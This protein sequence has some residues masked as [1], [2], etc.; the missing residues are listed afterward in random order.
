MLKNKRFTLFL[1]LS[2]FFIGN[3]L[4]A[5][6]IGVKI[7]SL[8]ST[9]GFDPLDLTVFGV[10]GLGMNLSAGVILWPIV[11][12]M[13]DIINEYF[14]EKN[15][16]FLS[17]LAIGIV[18]YS[19]AMIYGAIYLAPNDW[20]DSIS[21]INEADPNKSIDSMNNAFQKI[22]GQG[23]WIIVGSMVAF[24]IGQVVDVVT[25]HK[26]R[27]ITGEEKIWLRATGSTLVSQF[28]DSFVVLFIAFYIGADWDLIRVLA[29]GVV[30]YSYK[31]LMA[32]LLT[33]VI[34]LG[35][36]IIDRYLGKELATQMKEEAAI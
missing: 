34:Y 9:F 31:F 24:L 29:I 28:I 18:V 11:F 5:E 12:V 6:F 2:G 14:G 4:V 17:Y 7:F 3:T 15:V 25:F 16:K 1:I 36:F 22:M 20:W 32:I 21:G 19:F 30:N 35:H 10:D 27:K 26:I 13:T 23:L 33:P 8:E